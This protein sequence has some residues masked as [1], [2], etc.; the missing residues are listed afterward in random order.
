[1]FNQALKYKQIELL[2]T[3]NVTKHRKRAKTGNKN[4]PTT[5]LATVS[6]KGDNLL[7]FVIPFHKSFSLLKETLHKHWYIIDND[8]ILKKVFPKR[9]FIS[10]TRHENLHDH[11]IRAKLSKE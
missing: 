5:K 10:Y 8:P 2:G 3:T 7:P 9:P 4:I 11:L 1:M 6:K